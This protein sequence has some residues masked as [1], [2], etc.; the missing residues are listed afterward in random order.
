VNLRD[1]SAS[2]QRFFEWFILLA[3][4]G[5]FLVM[6]PGMIKQALGKDPCRDAH[7][8]AGIEACFAADDCER[9]RSGGFSC[10]TAGELVWNRS[11][12]DA[13]RLWRI[14]C[15]RGE[16]ASCDELKTTT[17]QPP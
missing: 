4:V 5:A 1:R 3:F 15:K 2:S 8:H 7:G 13:A 12:K 11:S 16:A 17:V 6:V 9:G 14:G 10:A